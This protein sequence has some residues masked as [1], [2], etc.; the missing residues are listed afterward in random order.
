M[1]LYCFEAIAALSALGIVFVRNVFYGALLLICCL[2]SIAA[3]FVFMNAEFVAVTQILVY[4]GGV[5]VLIIFGIMLSSKISGK[6]LIVE[7]NYIVSGA[8]LGISLATLLSLTFYRSGLTLVSEKS[9]FTDNVAT[10]GINIMSVYIL[11]FEV[12]GML[13]LVALIGAVVIASSSKPKST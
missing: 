7:H 9:P 11:P 13:L 5:L 4:A 12:A 3:L 1:L 6:P 10:V 8:L 2:L